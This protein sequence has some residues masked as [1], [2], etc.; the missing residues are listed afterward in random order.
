MNENEQIEEMA[1][2]IDSE[3]DCVIPCQNCAYY[4]YANCRNV[5]SAEKLYA[6]DYRKASEVVKI[7]LEELELVLFEYDSWIPKYSSEG[8]EFRYGY[9]QAISDIVNVKIE[10]L[11]KRFGGNQQ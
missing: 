6:K 2:N 7:I 5:K 9:S 11:K 10:E 8:A 1:K 3:Y 4:G